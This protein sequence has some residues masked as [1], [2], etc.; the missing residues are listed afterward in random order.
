MENRNEEMNM[1]ALR[2]DLRTPIAN[3]IALAQLS[4][5]ML[6][7]EETQES[8]L[9]YLSKIILAAQQLQQLTGEEAGDEAK[10]EERFTALEIAQALGTAI[11]AQAAQKN[12]ILRMDVSGMGGG[13]MIGRRTALLRIL[14]NLL[15]NAVKYTPCGGR[16]SLTARR[17]DAGNAEFVIEDNGMGMKREFMARM[18]EPFARAPEVDGG[19]IEGCGLGLSIVRRLTAELG[20]SIQAASEWGKGTTFTLRLPLPAEQ[21]TDAVLYGK[22]FLLAED[23]ELSAEIVQEILAGKGASVRRAGDGEQAVRLF[24]S[25]PT[26]TFD[27][28]L[29]DMHMPHLGGCAA[30]EAIRSYARADAEKIPIFALTAG[31]DARDECEALAAGMNACLRKP[32]NVARLCAVIQAAE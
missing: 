13:M 25:L 27:A 1:R 16:I 10:R 26:G 6:E 24:E 21:K 31:E 9:P 30:A 7:H 17:T 22:C 19:E 29:M 8:I 5:N 3:V 15:G 4:M 2:H 32:L 11:G 18:F 12:Q 28:I 14:T 23:N 20:G